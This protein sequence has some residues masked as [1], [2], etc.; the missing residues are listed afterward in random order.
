MRKAL[1]ETSFFS[2]FSGTLE[3]EIERNRKKQKECP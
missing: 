2:I 1:Q 3:H